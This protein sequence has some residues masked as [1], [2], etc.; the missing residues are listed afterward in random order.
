MTERTMTK[1]DL[2]TSMFLIV[3]A[4]AIIFIS[5]GMPTMADRNASPYS[6]P[7][8][9]PVF[10]GV[11]IFLLSSAML[12]RSLR[13]GVRRMFSEDRGKLSEEDRSSWKRIAR[14]LVLCVLYVALLGKVWFPLL[15]F[16]FVFLFIVT[17]EY[18]PK[19]PP[20]KQWKIPLT[21]AILAVSTA[22]SVFLVFQYLFLVNLP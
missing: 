11:M 12:I 6:G 14:T 16:L 3:F 5:L 8:V 10:I 15:T 2:F 19:A 7:G 1:A 18:D 13:R 22:A 17:F 4:A 9:V 20:G 21:A